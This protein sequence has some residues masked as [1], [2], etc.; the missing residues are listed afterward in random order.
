MNEVSFYPYVLHGKASVEST[1]AQTGLPHSPCSLPLDIIAVMK[2]HLSEYILV[3][4]MRP[5]RAPPSFDNFS[6]VSELRYNLCGYQARSH[7]LTVNESD[8]SRV[9]I[10]RLV[11]F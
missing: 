3:L 5:F 11:Y 1:P 4:L 6:P 7:I 2:R 10:M 9:R 8:V